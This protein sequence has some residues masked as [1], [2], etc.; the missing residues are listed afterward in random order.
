M[1]P[2]LGGGLSFRAGLGRGLGGLTEPVKREGSALGDVRVRLQAWSPGR[3]Q[4]RLVV[5]LLHLSSGRWRPWAAA[6]E[7]SRNSE[8][9]P[10]QR[11]LQFCR[12]N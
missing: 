12:L 7:E 4:E 8:G 2:S 9:L 1:A 5:S 10:E 11:L 6:A 3:G